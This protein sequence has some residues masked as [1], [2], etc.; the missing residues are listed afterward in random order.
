LARCTV[1]TSLRIQYF[2]W[3][4][5]LSGYT[6]KPIPSDIRAAFAPQLG[7]ALIQAAAN[8]RNTL[9]DS[10][11]PPPEDM[12]EKGSHKITPPFE[13]IAELLDALGGKV[14]TEFEPT[15]GEVQLGG[16][17]KRY[18]DWEELQKHFEAELDVLEESLLA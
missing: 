11:P 6:Q 5:E 17:T 4:S 13:Q 18:R 9:I 15:S 1:S 3:E 7:E 8:A 12:G 2:Y 10:S 14:R 16:A